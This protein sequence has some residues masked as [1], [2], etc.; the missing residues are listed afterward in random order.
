M[1]KL[2]LIKSMT[3]G[4]I[5]FF[6]LLNSKYKSDKLSNSMILFNILAKMEQYDEDLLKQKV[7][8]HQSI[9]VNLAFEKHRLYKQIKEALVLYHAR[10]KSDKEDAL[11]LFKFCEVLYEKNLTDQCYQSIERGIRL[12]TETEDFL[13]KLKFLYFK[14]KLIYLNLSYK[15]KSFFESLK[16]VEQAIGQCKMVNT[17]FENLSFLENKIIPIL[18]KGP[19][20]IDKEPDSLKQKIEKQLNNLPKD[21]LSKRE[22]IQYHRL[23]GWYSTL[24]NDYVMSYTSM[25]QALEL[26]DNNIHN[27]FDTEEQ[28]KLYYNY[29]VFC[30]HVNKKHTKESLE[31]RNKFFRIKPDKG[32]PTLIHILDISR[33]SLMVKEGLYTKDYSSILAMGQQYSTRI[34][35]EWLNLLPNV[36]DHSIFML[37]YIS[38]S[39]GN[40]ELTQKY[41]DILLNQF[42]KEMAVN[43]RSAVHFMNIILQYELKNYL[44][45]S[46]LCD[47]ARYFS[48]SNNQLDKKEQLILSWMKS[49]LSNPKVDLPRKCELLKN[50][51]A[52][53]EAAGQV[54]EKIILFD[55]MAWIESKCQHKPMAHFIKIEDF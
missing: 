4:E 10:L 48:K 9:N 29:F 21:F 50:K 43:R 42:H 45:I 3:R 1:D 20:A 24:N 26:I 14:R 16:A 55:F 2:S 13:L 51:L 23:I 12:T 53:L 15:N 22:E 34:K 31:S 27:Y 28:I 11:D 40:Y 52:K 33:L 5:R 47:A 8:N 46:S 39:F 41:M 35:K 32:H 7:A 30:L 49:S 38:L 25:R 6:K 44:V 18:V 37:G 19:N 36:L 17:R 54:K